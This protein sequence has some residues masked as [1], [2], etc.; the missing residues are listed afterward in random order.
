MKKRLSVIGNNVL[1]KIL[2]PL[3]EGVIIFPESFHQKFIYGIVLGRGDNVNSSI[4]NESLVIVSWTASKTVLGKDYSNNEDLMVINENDI[5]MVKVQKD[6][7]P[8]GK[9]ALV[10]RLNTDEK[11][12]SII[13]HDL[14]NVKI[15]TLFGVIKTLGVY[16]LKEV[17]CNARPGD[18]VK[19]DK[20]SIEIK[21]FE[22]FGDYCLIV[23]TKQLELKVDDPSSI[24]PI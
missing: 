16:D 23:P 1:I 22:M 20:W 21:E 17:D 24:I 5:L 9:N 4:Q 7:K 12:G 15:Q 11:V 3:Y 6:F 2:R 19:I 18:I 13:V 10:S 14:T 8:F